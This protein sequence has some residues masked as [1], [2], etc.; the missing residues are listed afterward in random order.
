MELEK[1]P[2]SAIPAW[3]KLNGV[4]FNGVTISQLTGDRGL[5]VVGDEGNSERTRPLMLVP[6][7]L[8]LSVQNVFIFAK[9]DQHLREILEAVGDYSRV[10][11]SVGIDQKPICSL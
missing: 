7:D 6:A 3:V 1:L 5:G 4:S 11:Q 2:V 10:P 8:I 9:S